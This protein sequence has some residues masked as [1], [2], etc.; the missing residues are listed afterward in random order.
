MVDLSDGSRVARRRL[1]ARLLWQAIETGKVELPNGTKMIV[2]PD[3]WLDIIQFLYKHIDGPPKTSLDDMADR[4]EKIVV[5]L[6]SND[7]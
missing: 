2:S 7:D 4:V 5:T 1:M 6:K 3:D